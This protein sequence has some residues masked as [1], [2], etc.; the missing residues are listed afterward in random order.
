MDSCVPTPALAGYIPPTLP[1]YN[2]NP[3]T[4]ASILDAAGFVLGTDDIRDDPKTGNNLD[5]LEMY[6]R[7]DDPNRRAAGELLRDA[8]LDVGIPVNCHITEKSVCYKEVMVEYDF[9]IYTGGWLLGSDID[10]LYW[11]WSS[12]M[13]FGG[14]ATSYY[15]GVGW[16]LN[17]GGICV[18]TFDTEAGN[19]LTAVNAAQV[20]A[21]AYTAQLAFADAVGMIPLW[22]SAAVKAYRSGWSGVVNQEGYG[23]DNYWTFLNM[24]K[25]GDDTIDYGF[26]SNLEGPSVICAEWVW[27]WNVLGLMY[28][29]MTGLNPYNFAQDIGW[30]AEDWST[31]E[32]TPGKMYVLFDMVQDA[33]FHD[34]TPVLPED[35]QFSLE[36]TR[37]C[38]P[39][40]AWNYASAMDI[41]HVDT[42]A[43]DATLG[44][45]QVKVYFTYTSY[46]MLHWA[47]GLPIINK[48]LWMAANDA[49]GWGYGTP[50]WDPTLVRDYHLWNSD[51]NDN[52]IV[53]LAEDG[54]GAWVW[55]ST[56]RPEAI[57]ASTWI[58]LTAN[59]DFYRSQTEISDF[60][61]MAFHTIGDINLGSN[62][63]ILDLS[64]IARGLGTDDTYPWGTGFDEYNPDCDIFTCAA[65]P[66]WIVGDGLINVDDLTT[67]A[68]NYGRVSG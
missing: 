9:H 4:A 6:V 38:G 35:V 15:G 67:A 3:A 62:I 60:L 11:L 46:W 41:D 17:Y 40:V 49:Y 8:L 48:D 31:G 12:E 59:R 18:P 32:W 2:Y 14:T 39:G 22:C 63:D 24:E 47:G 7:I 44:D 66:T 57:S 61:E 36:F 33:V 50:G 26:K 28:D 51:A 25:T 1:I 21:A 16:S 20:R 52:G 23:M 64:L 5:P 45:W 30:L 10:W 19:I 56:E 55:D 42:K 37:D 43:E 65:W 53:D 68:M 54:T 34:G 27:D 13:Y 58:L 29:S